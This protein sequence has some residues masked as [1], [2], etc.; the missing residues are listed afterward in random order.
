MQPLS[1][2]ENSGLGKIMSPATPRWTLVKPPRAPGQVSGAARATISN[3]E[4]VASC[5]RRRSLQDGVQRNS[6]GLVTFVGL[7][8]IRG[9]KRHG[10]DA[11][12]C[13]RPG[14]D[15][16]NVD[17]T[18]LPK[19][20]SSTTKEFRKTLQKSAQ[21][22]RFGKTQMDTALHNLREISGNELL[23]KIRSNGNQL[24]IGDVTF[25]LAESYG[26]CWGVER[27]VA[28]AREARNYF[29]G[30]QIWV[31]NE[32]VHNPRVNK[33]LSDLGMKFVSKGPNA[34]KDFSGVQEGDV[35]ILPAFGASVN[36]MAFLKNKKVQ[37]VDATCPWVS[38]VWTSVEKSKGKGHTSIIHGKY[39]H[40]E[41]VAT[42]SFAGKY[43]VVKNMHEAEFVAQ[44]MLGNGSREEFMAKF[45]KATS[46]DFD[47]D[48]DLEKVGIANQTTMLK[49][50]TELIGKLFERVMIKK[51][52]P[53]TVND[54]FVS[55]N[56]ICDATQQRQDA[57]YSMFLSAYE[58]PQSQLYAELEGEQV[59]VP[60]QW[61]KGTEQLS[62]KQME[63]KIRGGSGNSM[64]SN[65]PKLDICLVVGGFNSS[66]TSHLLEIAE[67]EGALGYHIDCAD[68]IGEP[69]GVA[70][71]KIQHKPL[72]TPPAQAMMDEGLEVKEGFLPEGPVVIGVTSGAS[73]PDNV[74][75]ECLQR[76]LSVKGSP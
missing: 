65:F 57:M 49:G 40:E 41:T 30:K 10:R 24:R 58:P 37:I 69:Y 25:V 36:E 66:N 68:R 15:A 34:E 28:M 70:T 33:D 45:G 72:S 39:D 21:Y 5:A 2:S 8:V 12:R 50:E 23:T 59:N 63:D 11:Q 64:P 14:A 52:G 9:R 35:V 17:A 18:L 48:A 1:T 67:E 7:A 74:L 4:Q 31:S 43:L 51:Y 44:Y 20:E 38:K 19:V 75:G 32:I 22:F 46:E 16:Q 71:N 42:R 62:S 13:S 61:S 73:T 56:T 3:T 27:A 29:T 47:P 53:H 6:M 26:L 54:H 55:F 60:L 76:I